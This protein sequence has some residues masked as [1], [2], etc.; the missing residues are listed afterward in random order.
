MLFLPKI[1]GDLRIKYRYIFIISV[2]CMRDG[3]SYPLNL[4]YMSQ[5][6]CDILLLPS[7]PQYPHK[8]SLVGDING[9]EDKSAATEVLQIID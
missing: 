9:A 5:P 4:D 7:L 1:C 8:Y 3:N 2:Y 6:T